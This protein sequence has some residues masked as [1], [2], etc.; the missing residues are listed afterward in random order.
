MVKRRIEDGLFVI[1]AAFY[2]D[3]AQ[4]LRPKCVGPGT[5]LVEAEA[6]GLLGIQ[7]LPRIFNAYEGNAQ[8]EEN[9]LS[10]CQG[11]VVEP[12]ADVVTAEFP[13]IVF[14]NLV[15]PG[16]G[17]PGSLGRHGPLLFPVAGGRR[18]LTHP[19]HKVDG[20]N[21]LPVVAEGSHE[22]GAFHLSGR[23]PPHGGAAL[24]G[25]ALPQI[26]ED[27]ALPAGERVALDGGARGSAYLGPDAAEKFQRVVARMRHLILVFSSV[28]VIVY[29]E[30][31][32]GGHGEKGPQLRAAHAGKVHMRKA[33]KI[34]VFLHIGR[35][36]PPAVL[37]PGIHGGTHHVERAHAHHAVGRDGTGIASA[38]VGRADK[39]IHPL[40]LGLSAQGECKEKECGLEK[41]FHRHLD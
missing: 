13:R 21:G 25:E 5:D 10:L 14:I 16:I 38:E 39:G 36:P 1:R 31:A 23:Y 7:V 4:M 15:L 37:V 8:L 2:P 28:H 32:R 18:N 12:A 19:Q 35:A 9:L 20:E 26:E 22:L 34:A 33:C 27:V 11:I 17:I 24:V 40:V 30:R 3:T 29:L 41:M 6:R